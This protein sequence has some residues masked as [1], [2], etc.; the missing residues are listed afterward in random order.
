MNK[1]PFS[2]AGAAFA[3]LL[4]LGS[5]AHAG[6]DTYTL[7]LP[8]VGLNNPCTGKADSID[9]DLDLHIVKQHSEG[10]HFV[11]VH[12]KGSGVDGYGKKYNINVRKKFQFHDPLPAQVYL[13]AKLVSQGSTDNAS[14][15]VALHVNEQGDVTKAEFSGVECK[16]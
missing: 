11:H 10:V 3:S 4:S 8:I 1:L 12:A 7:S 13:S 5:A 2:L 16:G 14:L 15:V 9:G 6:A